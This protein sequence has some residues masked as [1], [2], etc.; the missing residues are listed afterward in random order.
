MNHREGTEV[1][2]APLVDEW[3]G[4][5]LS[6]SMSQGGIT[7]P[8]TGKTAST[9]DWLLTDQTRQRLYTEFSTRLTARLALIIDNESHATPLTGPHSMS[10]NITDLSMQIG[11][12]THGKPVVRLTVFCHQCGAMLLRR[13]RDIRGHILCDHKCHGAFRRGEHQQGQLP[14]F[15]YVR[16]LPEGTPP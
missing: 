9:P 7:R 12:T 6:L 1:S 3:A 8:R 5:S 4:A 13:F 11:T 16:T 10:R 2:K 14:L 15:A